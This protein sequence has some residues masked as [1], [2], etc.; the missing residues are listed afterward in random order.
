MKYLPKSRFG[1]AA[2][3]LYLL[4]VFFL[5]AITVTGDRGLHSGAAM[6]ALFVFFLTLPLS[7][8]AL[9][10][11]NY[12][13]PTPTYESVDYLFIVLLTICA[14]MNAAIIYLLV[15]LVS[16]A[17]RALFRKNLK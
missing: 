3:G 4:L 10:A 14:F 12:L 17:L 7:W 16:R 15:G 11:T 2:A 6:T 1:A 5:S 9:S 8:L 13:N